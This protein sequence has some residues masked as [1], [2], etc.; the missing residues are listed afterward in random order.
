MKF[1]LTGSGGNIS[2]PRIF[3]SC[4]I[5]NLA[6]EI[7][8]PYKRNSSCMYLEDIEALF[9]CP[10]DIS[11]SLNRR[12]IKSVQNLFITHW[13][14]DHTFGLRPLLQS[15]FDFFARKAET[16]MNIFISEHIYE[17]LKKIY[18]AIEHFANR[19]GLANLNFVEHNQVLTFGDITVR[20]IGYNGE[21]SE[22]YAFEIRQQGKRALYAPCDT[23]TFNQPIGD[24]DLLINECG[25]F[26]EVEEEMKFSDLMNK[27]RK[28]KVKKT[29]MTHIEEIVM[30]KVGW[31][32]LEQI[33]KEYPD[34][35]FDFGYDGMV[36]EV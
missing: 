23:I 17:G 14:P 20:V 11:D 18:P 4:D 7:G 22:N 21:K 31:N 25:I 35:D 5:C 9:D 3:C 34:I 6:R 8:E 36:I 12:N 28:E 33:K 32:Y 24:V 1:I 16:K 30:N 15:N 2:T 10:E 19:M 29:V 13:H 26:V 27:I